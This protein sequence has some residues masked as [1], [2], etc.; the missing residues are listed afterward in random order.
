[1]MLAS[2]AALMIGLGLVAYGLVMGDKG[3]ILRERFENEESA[4][5]KDIR[6]SE[7]KSHTSIR[8][9]VF[10]AGSILIVSDIPLILFVVTPFL[11]VW[12]QLQ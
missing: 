6:Y 12:G 3:K 10:L 4:S 8:F 7:M 11:Y 9:L 5:V 1:M 2:L